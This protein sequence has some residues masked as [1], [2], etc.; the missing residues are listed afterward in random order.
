MSTIIVNFSKKVRNNTALR[1]TTNYVITG[2]ST[3]AVTAI[4]RLNEYLVRL[5]I[6]KM[7]HN[8]NYLLTIS[9]V[10]TAQGEVIVAPN[11]AVAFIGKETL[12]RLLN[13]ASAPSVSVVRLVF[14]EAMGTG[15]G[16]TSITRVANYSLICDPSAFIYVDSVGHVN[17]TTVELTVI[18]EMKI[19][20]AN[21]QV[22]VINIVDAMGNPV[23]PLYSTANF[24][25]FGIVPYIYQVACTTITNIK[26]DF[27]ETMHAVGLDTPANYTIGV[28]VGAPALTIISITPGGVNTYVNIQIS[29]VMLGGNNN[30]WISADNLYD[31]VGHPI[32]TDPCY[33]VGVTRPR[34]ASTV[35][36]GNSVRVTFDQAMLDGSVGTTGLEDLDNYVF[37]SDAYYQPTITSVVKSANKRYV[38]VNFSGEMKTGSNN[39]VIKAFHVISTFGAIDTNHD[40][41]QFSGAGT[42]PQGA[43]I[44]NVTISSLRYNFND[45][46]SS[47]GLSS[48]G[49]Y[50]LDCPAGAAP[51]YI[52]SVTPGGSNSYVDIG[53]TGEPNQSSAYSVTASSVTDPVGNPITNAHWHFTGAGVSP[54][55]VSGSGGLSEWIITFSE[56]MSDTVLTAGNYAVS[57]YP[58]GSQVSVASVHRGT[59]NG[60]HLVISGDQETGGAYVVTVTG[61]LDPVGNP[62]GSPNTA[63][64]TGVGTA[65]AVTGVAVYT[66]NNGAPQF[67]LEL[68]FNHGVKNDGAM[69][70][71]EN[72]VLTKARGETSYSPTRVVG[73]GD[74][75]NKIRIL[76]DYRKMCFNITHTVTV[77]NLVSHHNNALGASNSA[78]CT[79][80]QFDGPLLLGE[81]SSHWVNDYAVHLEFSDAIY[82]LDSTFSKWK[83]GSLTINDCFPATPTTVQVGCAEGMT[84]G[85]DYLCGVLSGN[86]SMDIAGNYIGGGTELIHTP[87]P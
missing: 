8:G 63:N 2:A 70:T 40:S 30:Y 48:P 68:T 18:G 37:Y 56:Y 44:T 4:E 50:N 55:V 79:G 35:R 46:M 6:A 42:A 57:T 23:D 41:G 14:N 77:S 21:Y 16:I 51:I 29:G 22:N 60:V 10:S 45:Y 36:T 47:V 84:L 66:W 31:L 43:G 86:T 19:G 65:L 80:A 87:E 67:V 25:G 5:T 58:A 9:N 34:V 28:P 71:A 1:T 33:F 20:V 81:L 62:I 52:S 53:F 64:I 61:V 7:V 72:Y 49:N 13:P 32:N 12:V 15:S 11:N 38:D 17:P 83:I 26:V 85:L 69:T 74:T 54:W 82:S 24:N 73:Y 75:N 27:S 76:F 39:Y 78:G 59:G 3:P